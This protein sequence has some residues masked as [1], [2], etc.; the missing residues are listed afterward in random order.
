MDN[1]I[2][3][4][5][6]D[7]IIYLQN[8]KTNLLLRCYIRSLISNYYITIP[9]IK[10]GY[11]TE[12]IRDNSLDGYSFETVNSMINFFNDDASVI[13]G[14]LN[15]KLDHSWIEF[16][17]GNKEYVFDPEFN[18]LVLKADYEKNLVAHKKAQILASDVKDNLLDILSKGERTSDGWSI[19][20]AS[21]DIFNPF[22][23]SDMLVEGTT[24]NKR[25]L[26][27]STRF[28]NK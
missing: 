26:M 4:S 7:K 13:R 25:V 21:N 23:K 12:M 22:Y 18:I 2:N 17:V 8:I 1:I 28:K 16:K 5:N 19:I 9:N 27:L 24:I 10:R 20:S 15:F 11:A 3:L 6:E 14:D